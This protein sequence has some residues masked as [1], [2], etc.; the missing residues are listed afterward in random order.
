MLANFSGL[1]AAYENHNEN[2]EHHVYQ[3]D[4]HK[5]VEQVPLQHNEILANKRAFCGKNKIEKG[6]TLQ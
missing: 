3:D 4:E 6:Y 5:E 2:P 1:L